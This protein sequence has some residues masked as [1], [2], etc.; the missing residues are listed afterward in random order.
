M[1]EPSCKNALPKFLLKGKGHSRKKRYI[2]V[3]SIANQRQDSDNL[4]KFYGLFGFIVLFLK[5]FGYKDNKET[6]QGYTTWNDI[7]HKYEKTER[8]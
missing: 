1:I 2:T 4:T 7:S 8:R 6:S 3:D 5:P